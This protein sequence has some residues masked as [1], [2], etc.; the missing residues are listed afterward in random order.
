MNEMENDPPPQG[1]KLADQKDTIATRI[2]IIDG[3][4][5]TTRTFSTL[6]TNCG[7]THH[8]ALKPHLARIVAERESV[9][10]EKQAIVKITPP[11]AM[12]GGKNTPPNQ[13]RRAIDVT[14]LP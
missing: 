2:I 4:N 1:E 5:E 10:I 9:K 8:E 3:I 7:G 12:H 6:M 13:H 11:Q 14:R